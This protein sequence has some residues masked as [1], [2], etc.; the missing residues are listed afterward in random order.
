[1][2]VI[3][4]GINGRMVGIARRA[5]GQSRCRSDGKASCQKPAAVLDTGTVTVR[6]LVDS[7]HG[8]SMAAMRIKLRAC[9]VEFEHKRT[10]ILARDCG[11]VC[12]FLRNF[13]DEAFHYEWRNPHHALHVASHVTLVRKARL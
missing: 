6:V 7:L 3:P 13:V 9:S 1:M 8:S 11:N 10:V 5:P 12:R 4:R 2:R